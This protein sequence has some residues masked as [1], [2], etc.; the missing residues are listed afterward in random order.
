MDD[1]FADVKD[2]NGLV[3]KFAIVSETFDVSALVVLELS[4]AHKSGCIL[5]TFIHSTIK[6]L[7]KKKKSV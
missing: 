5:I 2:D 7:K 4:T 3:V 1:G 6:Y